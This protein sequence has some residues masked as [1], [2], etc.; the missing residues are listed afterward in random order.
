[1]QH[2]IDGLPVSTALRKN[3]YSHDFPTT[4]CSDSA[5][6]TRRS[7]RADVHTTPVPW[8]GHAAAAAIS[9]TTLSLYARLSPSLIRK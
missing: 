5:R 4:F 8:F 7:P 1:L 6:A 2:C 3:N 9:P